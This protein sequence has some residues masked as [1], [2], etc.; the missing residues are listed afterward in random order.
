VIVGASGAAI[1]TLDPTG[2]ASAWST[3][4]ID[5]SSGLAGVSCVSARLCVAVDQS[6]NALIGTR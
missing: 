2:A 6:R 4:T 5:S 3:N 1:T